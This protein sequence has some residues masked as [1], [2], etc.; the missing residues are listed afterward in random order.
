MASSLDYELVVSSNKSPE[1]VRVAANRRFGI[2]IPIQILQQVTKMC[3]DTPSCEIGGLLVGRYT[4]D[5]V[6]AMVLEA[7]SAPSDSITGP[8]WFIRGIKGLNV[9]LALWWKR[10]NGYYLGE[11][12]YHPRGK[13]VPSST[14]KAQMQRISASQQ[15]ACPEPILLII[16]GS[17]EA[18]E[19]RSFVFPRNDKFIELGVESSFTCL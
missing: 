14:D 9:K 10:E 18:F 3:A 15:Y 5:Q 11:W 8:S 2:R 17:A 19:I 4:E 7:W 16:G 1:Y 13:A 12:H 6:Y